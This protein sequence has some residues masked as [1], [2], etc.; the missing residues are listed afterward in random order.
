MYINLM[1]TVFYAR[2]M[3]TCSSNTYKCSFCH[4]VCWKNWKFCITVNAVSASGS[5]TTFASRALMCA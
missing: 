3:H 5:G 4:L 1:L 2:D